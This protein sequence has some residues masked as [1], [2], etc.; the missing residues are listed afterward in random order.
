MTSRLKRL[1][2]PETASDILNDASAYE[3]D[4]AAFY[5]SMD[6][7]RCRPFPSSSILA[8]LPRNN[9]AADIPLIR[10]L[11]PVQRSEDDRV[12]DSNDKPRH[13]HHVDAI[14][15]P[16]ALTA[17][18]HKRYL[19]LKQDSKGSWSDLRRKEWKKL[20]AAVEKEQHLYR[21]AVAEFLKTH[22]YRFLVGFRRPKLSPFASWHADQVQGFIQQWNASKETNLKFG[23]CRQVASLLHAWNE[24]PKASPAELFDSLTVETTFETESRDGTTEIKEGDTLQAPPI[25]SVPQFLVDDCDLALRLAREHGATIVTT[26]YT[27][28][29]LIGGKNWWIP[30]TRKGG[31]VLLDVPLPRPCTTRECLTN[32]MQDA[33]QTTS[34]FTYTLLT[35]KTKRKP[36]LVLVRGS[37]LLMGSMHVH[38]EYFQERGWERLTTQE[39]ASWILDHLLGSQTCI[40][41]ICPASS[42]VLRMDPGGVAHALA[43]DQEPMRHLQVMSEVL[44]A[45]ETMPDGNLLLVLNGSDVRVHRANDGEPEIDLETEFAKVDA[46]NTGA[47]ALDEC[48]LSWEW[49][50]DRIPNTFPIGSD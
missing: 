44:S 47:S 3:W 12:T 25:P 36:I 34:A 33:I 32:G 8:S 14:D 4:W 37:K 49:G 7:R 1:K 45:T 16:S 17:G 42:K 26:D 19:Q 48:A 39:R 22:R 38:L 24:S 30:M 18:Q 28:R 21:Q 15:N 13:S 11:L 5:E 50:N 2:I 27:L 29:A 46:V 10:N 20:R 41:R 6:S 35:L 9:T 40:A 23:K 31:C 43:Q